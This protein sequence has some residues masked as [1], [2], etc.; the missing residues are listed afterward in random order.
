MNMIIIEVYIQMCLSMLINLC[1]LDTLQ[2]YI[3]VI[4]GFFSLFNAKG[5]VVGN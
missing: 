5:P 2:P 1:N 4:H 3:I